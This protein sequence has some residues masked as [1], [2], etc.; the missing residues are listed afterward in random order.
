MT[1]WAELVACRGDDYQGNM[2][3]CVG[4]GLVDIIGGAVTVS[5]Y[6]DE[7]CS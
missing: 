6:I 3:I 1:I 5:V 7:N 2:M 4:C